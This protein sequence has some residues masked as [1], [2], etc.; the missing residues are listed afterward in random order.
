MDLFRNAFWSIDVFNIALSIWRHK[1]TPLVRQE[2]AV[3]FLLLTNSKNSDNAIN[4]RKFLCSKSTNHGI[5]QNF[6]GNNNNFSEMKLSKSVHHK[7]TRCHAFMALEYCPLR[8]LEAE[9]DVR[10]HIQK[11]QNGFR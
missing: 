10:N 11:H 6:T 1:E 7:A 4:I 9:K 8:C 3:I 5:E 2:F